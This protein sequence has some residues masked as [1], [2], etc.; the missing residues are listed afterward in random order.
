MF[1]P[2]I[3]SQN[4]HMEIKTVIRL[5]YTQTHHHGGREQTIHVLMCP[6]VLHIRWLL[7]HMLGLLPLRANLSAW[8]L[9]LYQFF[10]RAEFMCMDWFNLALDCANATIGPMAADLEQMILVSGHY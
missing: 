6:I 2:H 4:I 5:K 9:V 3:I 10:S 8:L 1:Q 7:V